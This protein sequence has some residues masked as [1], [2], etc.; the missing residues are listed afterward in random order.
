MQQQLPALRVPPIGFAH[1]GAR[2]HAP[3]NTIDAFELALR[4]GAT[5]LETDAWLT[6]DGT[7]VLDHDGEIRR[8]LFKKPL[9]TLPR[10]EL[11]DHVPSLDELYA[12]CGTAYELSIDLK[13]PAAFDGVLAAA[14]AAGAETRLWVC[15]PDL[16]TLASWR[17]ETSARLVHS[18]RLSRLK[19][20]PERHAATLAS[21]GIDAVNMHHKDWSGGLA[22]LFHRFERY[23]LGW[24]AQF[25][26]ILTD[27]V[28]MGLDGV[29]SDHVDEMMAVI[30][31]Q[32]Q[33]G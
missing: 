20:G 10:S 4:L 31:A 9:A 30:D 28:R 25:E 32:T 7:V 33:G 13:D 17:D 6:S 18:T 24:D 14:R 11:G 23:C 21:R 26:R 19:A 1:R 15:H 5:G 3:E 29:Y 8:G 27:L 2:A 12:S 22:A 16:D